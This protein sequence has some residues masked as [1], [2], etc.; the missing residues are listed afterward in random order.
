MAPDRSLWGSMITPLSLTA[1]HRGSFAVKHL[2]GCCCSS[3][4]V[5]HWAYKGIACGRAS[6]REIF[7]LTGEQFRVRLYLKGQLWNI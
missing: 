7:E 1:E 5:G 3:F 4:T 6:H 2:K